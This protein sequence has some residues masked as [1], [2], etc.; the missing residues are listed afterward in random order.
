MRPCTELTQ[1]LHHLIGLFISLRWSKYLE[2][3]Q[4]HI[5]NCV[6]TSNKGSPQRSGPDDD[7]S[8]CLP[9]QTHQDSQMWKLWTGS[10]LLIQ[11]TNLPDFI[12]N[13]NLLFQWWQAHITAEK[14]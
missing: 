8:F 12:R 9:E 13:I 2:S 4:S 14:K 7:N 5:L 3:K 6:Q 10:K 11:V 1:A